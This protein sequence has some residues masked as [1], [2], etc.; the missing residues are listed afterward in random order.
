MSSGYLFLSLLPVLCGKVT[1]APEEQYFHS[2]CLHLLFNVCKCSLN[3]LQSPTP[4]HS[5]TIFCSFIIIFQMV[6]ASMTHKIYYIVVC[7]MFF[8]IVI[9]PLVYVIVFTISQ[10][11]TSFNKET[12]FS[13][14]SSTVSLPVY[15]QFVLLLLQCLLVNILPSL[16]CTIYIF[17]AYFLQIF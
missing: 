11:D 5:I 4:S 9:H 7:H 16:A 15:L 6:T 10:P 13:H 1:P 12:L 2:C 3:S 8:F 14:F 17:L